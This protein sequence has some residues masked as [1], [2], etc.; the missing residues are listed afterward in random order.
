MSKEEAFLLDVKKLMRKEYS[1]PKWKPHSKGNVKRKKLMSKGKGFIR[2]GGG[3]L[4]QD[5]L[6]ISI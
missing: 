3:S 4:I 5:I 6:R 2:C 1:L